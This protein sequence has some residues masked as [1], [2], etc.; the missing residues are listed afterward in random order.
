[1]EHRIGILICTS[2]RR[3][4]LQSLLVAL[5]SEWRVGTF[6]IIVDNGR[7]SS[8][9]IISP[10]KE[11]FEIH[12]CR[13]QTP[14]LVVARNTCLKLA[15]AKS[16]D[17]LAFIDD[18][19]VPR[20]GWLTNLIR[21]IEET[22]AD[23]VTGPVEPIFLT[24]PPR[25]ATQGGYF[26][27]N[28]H[29][30]Q[31]GNLIV[32]VATFPKEPTEWFQ[33]EFNL[34]GGEDRELLGR[35][36]AGGARREVAD[37]A[38]VAEYV[39][40]ERMRRRYLWRRGARDGAVI[41]TIVLI[42]HKGSLGAYIICIYEVCKKLGYAIDNLVCTPISPWRI[43]SVMYD[44]YAASGILLRLMG[45]RFSFYGSSPSYGRSSRWKKS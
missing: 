20:P 40:P 28:G 5:R 32:R 1:M 17:F 3:Q 14:G 31:T 11:Y 30:F 35:L 25:W 26:Q 4:H 21:K 6:L 18:D 44:I 45:L 27:Y 29:S 10:F 38:I 7:Q 16:A 37:D 13:L 15:L 19:E 36:V 8:E 42:R 34:L 39:P 43:N 23:F 24:S 22:R 33:M 41:A 2:D 9:E 12:Y